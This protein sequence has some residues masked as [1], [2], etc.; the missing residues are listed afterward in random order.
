VSG[1][2]RREFAHGGYPGSG[3][4]SEVTPYVLLCFVLKM[5]H[6]VLGGYRDGDE[7]GY[8]ESSLQRVDGNGYP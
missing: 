4:H 5:E 2:D 7:Y 8:R 1:S 3:P 6:L